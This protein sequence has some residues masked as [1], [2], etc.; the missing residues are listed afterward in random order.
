MSS[1]LDHFVHSLQSKSCVKLTLSRYEGSEPGLTGITIRP[2]ELKG[3]LHLSFLYRLGRTTPTKNFSLEEGLK[4]LRTLLAEE[5]SEANLF[6]TE[7]NF[8]WQRGKER[9]KKLP[10]TH[11]KVDL[12]HDRRKCHLISVESAPWMERL[13]LLQKGMGDKFRQVQ[14][15]VEL[16]E[17]TLP[18]EEIAARSTFRTAD[19]G[20]GKG[21]LT[22]VA[23]NFL[24][25]HT[26]GTVE[27]RG[28]EL[29]QELVD[30]SNQIARECQMEG[31]VFEA[32]EIGRSELGPLDLLIALHA[33]DTAT[34]DAIYA[35]IRAGAEWILVSPCCHK[36]VRP[37]LKPEGAATELTRFG[38]F[39]ERMAE[40][41]TDGARALL[42]E[43]EGFR[44]RVVEFV[45]AE[46]TLR[47]VMIIARRD[48]GVDRAEAARRLS[49]LKRAFGVEKLHLERL[50]E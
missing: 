20:C 48:G 50:L 7:G 31:L 35:G 4:Q 8:H 24:T 11:S 9:L 29:R 18:P 44:T 13:G 43:R 36:E 26:A 42:L 2:I 16:L 10:P 19:M 40:M 30:R 14:K 15:F 46:H 17:S 49:E 21:Y 33:C 25:S 47:N 5:F 38:I 22:F 6:T 32:G 28:I 37:Q 41:V 1:L 45:S 39:A 3:V 23:H 12:A 27:T 34:D